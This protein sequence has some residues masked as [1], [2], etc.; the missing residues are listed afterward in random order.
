MD[1]DTDIENG[2]ITES[3]DDFMSRALDGLEAA[4]KE[5]VEGD[6][7]AQQVADDAEIDTEAQA[8]DKADDKTEV[9]KSED[10]QTII[11]PQSM[12]AKDRE[13]FYALPPEDQKWLSERAKQQEADYTQKTMKLAEDQRRFD[14]LEQVIAP[15]RHALAMEGMDE[16]TAIGQLFALSDFANRDPVAF[17]KYLFQARGIPLS[18]LAESG[19][20]TPAADPQLTAM[21]E[22]LHGLKTHLTQQTEAQRAQQ[23]Q[24]IQREITAFAEDPAYRYYGDLEGEMIPLVQA[25][26]QAQPG[27]PAREYLARAYNAALANN[28]EIKARIEADANAQRIAEAKKA[29]DKARKAAG[30]NIRTG[31][32][33]PAAAAKAKDVDGFISALVDERMTG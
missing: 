7:V 3:M 1:T 4:E 2:E 23:A 14:R 12:S 27:L 10:A 20:G 26:R 6:A 19:G 21:R 15:R 11:A 16:S 5:D 28:S 8:E 13:R 22:E 18:Q 33:L 30:T 9:D 29:A 24:A 25:F 31:A 17:T 32:S